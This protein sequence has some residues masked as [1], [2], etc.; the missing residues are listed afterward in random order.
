MPAQENLD[1]LRMRP[2]VLDQQ[3]RCRLWAAGKPGGF[4]FEYLLARLAL[5]HLMSL[6][7]S[8]AWLNI[9]LAFRL[10]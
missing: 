4:E 8:Q 3:E 10:T 7:L 9:F 5:F 6:T 2:V 1:P